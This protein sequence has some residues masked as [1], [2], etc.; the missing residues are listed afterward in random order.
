[1]NEIHNSEKNKKHF[2]ILIRK[3]IQQMSTKQVPIII[4]E[5][6]AKVYAYGY[7]KP[8]CNSHEEIECSVFNCKSQQHIIDI[9]DKKK[10]SIA[11]VMQIIR[12]DLK[13]IKFIQDSLK[14]GKIKKEGALW[15]TIK[16]SHW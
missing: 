10:T 5:Q 3:A 6:L 13:D 12:D 2:E 7:C 16:A 1:M 11:G 8:L 4:P 14:S 9:S 15:K